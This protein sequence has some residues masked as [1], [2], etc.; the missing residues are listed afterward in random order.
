MSCLRTQHTN[1]G[2]KPS[3]SVSRNRHSKHMA[4]MLHRQLLEQIISIH[5]TSNITNTDIYAMTRQH[6][7]TDEIN[8]DK[9]RFTGHILRLLEGTPVRQAIKIA[10][11]PVTRGRRKTTWIQSTN[12][13]LQSVG[14]SN[15]GT[16]KIHES[17]NDMKTWKQK[18]D[19]VLPGRRAL[20][21]VFPYHHNI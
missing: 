13:L 18:T 21:S 10:L 8:Q 2:V 1:A 19:D 4:N 20:D 16:K 3:T 11:R 9:L 6:L 14:L 12:T 5:Y 17:V 7:W 15:L